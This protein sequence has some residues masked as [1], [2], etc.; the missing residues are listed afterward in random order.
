VATNEFENGNNFVCFIIT[1]VENREREITNSKELPINSLQCQD[2]WQCSVIF[3]AK[4]QLNCSIS[5]W[6]ALPDRT[7]V[8]DSGLRTSPAFM[9]LRLEVK[10]QF[11]ATCGIN[12]HKKHTQPP[13]RRVRPSC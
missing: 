7:W 4:D 3:H 11:Q 9:T 8:I 12:T 5:C 1:S 2:I 10:Y 6:V 13:S